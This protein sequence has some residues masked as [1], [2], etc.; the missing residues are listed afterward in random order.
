M[1][2]A[3][4][5]G[6]GLLHHHGLLERHFGD[7]G[8]QAADALGHGVEGPGGGDDLA[9]RETMGDVNDDSRIR[10]NP[11]GT[12]VVA[13]IGG[14]QLARMTHQAAIALGLLKCGRI[15]LCPVCW[16]ASVQL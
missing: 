7:L 2:A 5:V 10:R 4:G 8:G 13:M 6:P 14:G 16:P 11:L 9:P 3:V 1:P 12:P 15:W